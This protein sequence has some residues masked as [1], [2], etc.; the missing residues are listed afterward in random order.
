MAR[1]AGGPPVTAS[2]I[3]NA[4]LFTCL[5]LL[6]FAV[7]LAAAARASGFDLRKAIVE[8]RNVAAAILA[9]AVTLGIA[10]IVASTMH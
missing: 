6:A 5:G 1:L 8:D 3:L 4:F 10:W 2:P 7:A 9:A